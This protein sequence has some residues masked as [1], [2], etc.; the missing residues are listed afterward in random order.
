M[1]R[2]SHIVTLDVGGTIYK[3][4]R[5]TLTSRD[6]P[7]FFDGLLSGH[8][9]EGMDPS[10]PIFIDRDGALFRHVLQYLRDGVVDT[11]L[12]PHEWVGM[13]READY[14][15]LAGLVGLAT[16]QAAQAP[17]QPGA[18]VD[19][20]FTRLFWNG[21]QRKAATAWSIPDSTP[22]WLWANM[23]RQLY[24]EDRAGPTSEAFATVQ[25]RMCDA[26]WELDANR[27]SV[28]TDYTCMIVHTRPRRSGRASR[29]GAGAGAARRPPPPPRLPRGWWAIKTDD[30]EVYYYNASTDETTWD[31]PS[32]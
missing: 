11:P 30:G 31:R 14:F 6:S 23:R 1:A 21:M 12:Q 20:A 32:A 22:T 18:S 2:P 16:E 10:E 9:A 17:E 27:S 7:N 28:D 24:G 8:F 5:S 13:Q 25:Q 26:G 4:T 3:T 15:Q 29:A 19:M